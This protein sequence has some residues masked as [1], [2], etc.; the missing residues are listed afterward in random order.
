MTPA[1][2]RRKLLAVT[3]FQKAVDALA[4]KGAAHPD[5]WEEIEQRHTKARINLLRALGFEVT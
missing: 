2:R 3:R 4:F 1:E 5:D